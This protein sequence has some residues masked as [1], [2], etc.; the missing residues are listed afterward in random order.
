MWPSYLFWIPIS[1]GHYVGFQLDF[2]A[3]L[4]IFHPPRFW[5]SLCRMVIR[6]L[7]WLLISSTS[8]DGITYHITR[9]SGVGGP[10][11]CVRSVYWAARER[12]GLLAYIPK[13]VICHYYFIILIKAFLQPKFT[14]DCFVNVYTYVPNVVY[15][16][17]GTIMLRSSCTR[18]HE[19]LTPYITESD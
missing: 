2:S 14:S 13:P 12:C 6:V 8:R 10:K 1:H 18:G 17:N 3:R 16:R 15:N 5:F 7:S 19:C 11:S 4:A 9:Y